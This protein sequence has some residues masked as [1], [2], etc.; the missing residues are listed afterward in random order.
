MC[1]SLF[2][3]RLQSNLHKMTQIHIPCN[4]SCSAARILK[5]INI[6]FLFSSTLALVVDFILKAD[7]KS[8][9]SKADK[10]LRIIMMRKSRISLKSFGSIK[11]FYH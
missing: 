6:F 2:L 5:K 1:A 11:A 8:T 10:D 4:L 9:L 7:L 3:N